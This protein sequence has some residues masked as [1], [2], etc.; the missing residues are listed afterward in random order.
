MFNFQLKTAL[1]V[2]LQIVAENITNS[3]VKVTDL[4]SKKSS[5]V[6]KLVKETTQ[7]IPSVEFVITSLDIDVNPLTDTDLVIVEDLLGNEEV[8]DK[9]KTS[10]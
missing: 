9:K 4:L 5:N 2:N 6:V 8:Q 7:E 3:H 1:Q 10:F